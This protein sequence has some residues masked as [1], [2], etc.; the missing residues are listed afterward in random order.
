MIDFFFIRFNVSFLCKYLA[1]AKLNHVFKDSLFI[2]DSAHFKSR[3]QPFV[4]LLLRAS[5]FETLYE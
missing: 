4:D 2:A 5:V 3:P 1:F